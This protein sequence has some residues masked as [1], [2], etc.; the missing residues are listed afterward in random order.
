MINA[1]S[2]TNM[3]VRLKDGEQLPE[4]L[5]GLETRA[6]AIVAGIG[7]LRDVVMGYWD[8]QRYVEEPLDV[9]V[10]LLSLQG[11]IAELNGEAVLHA[12]VV[13]GREDMSTVGGHLIRATVHN[14]A[15]LLLVALPGV[16]MERKAEPTGLPGLYPSQ[17][18]GT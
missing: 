11:N 10:E 6:A 9:P 13:V 5:L 18:P 12:H 16:R 4:A 3:M 14:T 15:E 7:M 17:A 8:G 2:G 1:E